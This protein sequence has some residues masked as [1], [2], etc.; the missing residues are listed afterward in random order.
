MD[1]LHIFYLSTYGQKLLLKL[2]DPGEER[3]YGLILLHLNR[4]KLLL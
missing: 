3:G 1:H 2:R 4:M